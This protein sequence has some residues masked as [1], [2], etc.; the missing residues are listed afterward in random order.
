[1]LQQAIH[2]ATTIPYSKGVQPL[3]AKGPN[4]YCAVIRGP[5]L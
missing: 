1:M 5:H 3:L 4:I 2:K